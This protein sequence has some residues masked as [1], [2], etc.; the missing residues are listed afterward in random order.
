ML[1]GK[2]YEI[3]K[4]NILCHEIVGLKAQVVDSPDKNKKGLSGII[5][6]E[7]KN[8]FMIDAN[9]TEKKVPKKEAVFEFTIGNEKAIVE[10]KKICFRPEDRVKIFWRSY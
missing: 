8:I 1:K 5:V 9:G 6:D 3:T 10:G 4:K 7:T 2:N